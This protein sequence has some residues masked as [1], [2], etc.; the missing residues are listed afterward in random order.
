MHKADH[1]ATILILASSYTSEIHE[2]ICSC[3]KHFLSNEEMRQ[4]G[5]HNARVYVVVYAEFSD[6]VIAGLFLIRLTVL[7]FVHAIDGLYAHLK[8]N[9]VVDTASTSFQ[10]V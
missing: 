6:S 10:L 2:N 3:N 9:L 7:A 5:E 8:V 1:V 4:I